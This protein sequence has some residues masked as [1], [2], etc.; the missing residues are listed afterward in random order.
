MANLGAESLSMLFP[1]GAR[2]VPAFVVGGAAVGAVAGPVGSTAT[3]VAGL[4]GGTGAVTGAVATGFAAGALGGMSVSAFMMEW[5]NSILE[6]GTEKGYNWADPQSAMLAYQDQSVWDEG[7]DR[8]VKRGIPIAAASWLSSA[9]AGR[10]FVGNKFMPKGTQLAMFGAER[11]IVD[12]AFEALGETAALIASGQYTGSVQD[13]KE[14]SAEALGAVGMS[15]PTGAIALGSR[16]AMNSRMELGLQLMNPRFMAAQQVS[17]KRLL[18]WTD[19]AEKL[20]KITPEMAQDIRLGIGHRRTA[21]ELLGLPLDAKPSSNSGAVG[22]I[23][24]LLEAKEELEKSGSSVFSEKIREITEEIALVAETGKPI[25][26]GQVNLRDIEA[27]TQRRRPSVYFS[28]RNQVS[29]EQFV[30]DLET[31]TPRQLKKSRVFFDPF[32]AEK[33]KEKQDALQEQKSGT[34]DVGEQAQAGPGVDQEVR[35]ETVEATEEDVA[36]AKDGDLDEQREEAIRTTITTKLLNEEPLTPA[37]QEFYNEFEDVFTEDLEAARAFRDGVP[38]ADETATPET[39]E[40]SKDGVTTVR[41]NTTELN[42]TQKAIGAKAVLAARALRKNFPGVKIILHDN[43]ESFNEAAKRLGLQQNGRGFYGF[44][45]KEIHINL[46][47]AGTNTVAHEAFHAALR[48]SIADGDVQALMSDFVDTLK[49]VIPADSDLAKKLDAFS[50][51]YGDNFTNEEYVAEF[52]GIITDAYPKADT[53]TKGVIAR[54]IER[55]AKL[56]GVDITLPKDLSLIHISEPTRP[57]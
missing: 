23:M 21:N 48:N 18:E 6:V 34:V 1:L 49:K 19:N 22:R 31:L 30:K 43:T 29:R 11:A 9:V 45:S 15:T 54:F 52:F 50:Q 13:M 5:G 14:I 33:L 4:I 36:Q 2:I 17:N 35:V 25:G 32:T 7:T 28:G 10:L 41:R 53:K 16:M 46:V 37:E 24:Q 27:R 12:P 40:E 44:D 55:L 8:G 57:Y 47:N 39:S 51:Q 26:T 3:G 38:E 42:E 56:I 20:G